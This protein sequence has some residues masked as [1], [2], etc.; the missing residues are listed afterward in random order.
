MYT[1]SFWVNHLQLEPHPEGGYFREI[2]RSHEFMDPEGLPSRYDG[3]RSF[4]TSI[5]FLVSESSFS[6]FHRLKSHEVWHFYAGGTIEMF[7][8]SPEGVL[9]EIKIGANPEAGEVFQAH[10]PRNHWFA[11]RVVPGGEYGLVGCTVAPGFDFADF[12]MAKREKL[13]SRFPQHQA[14]IEAFTR[15]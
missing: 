4:S 1:E 2:Y 5:Y 6:S 11:A 9:T 3:P 13:I 14:L 10:V 15:V 8:I 7:Q 12:E